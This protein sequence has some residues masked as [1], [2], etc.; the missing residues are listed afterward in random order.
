MLLDPDDI[1]A[2]ARELVASSRPPGHR[3][4]PPIRDPRHVFYRP[5]FASPRDF[6]AG[7]PPD[8]YEVFLGRHLLGTVVQFAAGDW[9]CWPAADGTG[10]PVRKSRAEAARQLLQ[11]ARSTEHRCDRID[12]ASRCTAADDGVHRCYIAP[13]GRPHDCLCVC[14][15]HW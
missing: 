7:R 11:L 4:G 6:A 10:L 12:D 13:L 9:G 2:A 1:I 14:G 5:V 15:I 3:D 8:S